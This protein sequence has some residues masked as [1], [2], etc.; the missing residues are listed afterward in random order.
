MDSSTPVE[1]FV[2]GQSLSCSNFID[3][4]RQLNIQVMVTH[5]QLRICSYEYFTYLPI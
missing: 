2:F 5:T 1:M 4:F 3:S